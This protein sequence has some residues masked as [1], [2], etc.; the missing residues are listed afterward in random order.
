MLVVNKTKFQAKKSKFKL[1]FDQSI[2]E[3]VNLLE[4]YMLERYREYQSF[5]F[6]EQL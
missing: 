4:G 1:R 2:K 3:L 5:E 6:V